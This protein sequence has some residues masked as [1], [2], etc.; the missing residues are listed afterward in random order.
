MQR[1]NV[2]IVDN[3]LPRALGSSI[4]AKLGATVNAYLVSREDGL[5][6]ISGNAPFIGH[7]FPR[8]FLCRS[9]CV[10]TTSV[11]GHLRAVNLSTLVW[12]SPIPC[13]PKSLSRHCPYSYLATGVPGFGALLPKSVGG[14]DR[15]VFG[16]IYVTAPLAGS[17]YLSARRTASTSRVADAFNCSC[18]SIMRAPV[19]KSCASAV[20]A[21]VSARFVRSRSP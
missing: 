7:Q 2:D 4:R 14:W 17:A 6:H 1:R 11:S 10:T 13:R 3:M 19:A 16:L 18:R 5:F 9:F 15:A 8:L 12:R 20:A 21:R